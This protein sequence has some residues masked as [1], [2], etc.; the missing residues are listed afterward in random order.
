MTER[1]VALLLVVMATGIALYDLLLL[2][3]SV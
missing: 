1:S 3:V 2:A